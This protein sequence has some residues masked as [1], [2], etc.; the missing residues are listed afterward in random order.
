MHTPISNTNIEQSQVLI[1]PIE[2]KSKFPLTDLAE[3][4]VL[5]SRHEIEAI[6]DGKDKRKFGH[7]SDLLPGT[8]GFIYR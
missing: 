8:K 6:L 1:T 3:I 2:I 4:T 5:K 7:V